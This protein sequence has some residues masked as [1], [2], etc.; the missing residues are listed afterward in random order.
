VKRYVLFSNITNKYCY[1]DRLTKMHTDYSYSI[2]DVMII[3]DSNIH[4]AKS[5]LVNLVLN[6][7][8]KVKSR[9]IL[10]SDIP[11]TL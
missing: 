2:I 3:P 9:Y 5:G 11:I 6:D 4:I 10:E 8:E 1:L 7:S